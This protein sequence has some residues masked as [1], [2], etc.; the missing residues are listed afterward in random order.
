MC[1]I[2]RSNCRSAAT[3]GVDDPTQRRGGAHIPRNVGDSGQ[4]G[5][6]RVQRGE[7]RGQSRRKEAGERR[8]RSATA[9]GTAVALMVGIALVS[10]ATGAS[11]RGRYANSARTGARVTTTRPARGYT[12]S[13]EPGPCASDVPND[14]SV[15]CGVL[16][17]PENRDRPHRAEVQLPVA[18][19]RSQA[20]E[21]APDPIVYLTG[22]PG[23]AA[24]PII[25]FVLA[26]DLGGPRD[27]IVLSQRGAAASTPNLD[28][29][30]F[31]DGAWARFATADPD[32]VEQQ[33]FNQA[34]RAC[35]DRLEA[36]SVDL[37]AYNT[38]TNAADVADLR[39][40]LGILEWNIWSGS[41]GTVLAQEVMRHHSQGVRS[42]VLD[43]T[44]PLDKGFG[45]TGDVRRAMEA[46]EHLLAGCAAS[47]A[48]AAAHPTLASD[49]KEV[50]ARL[51]VQPYESVVA[52]DTGTQRAIAFTGRDLTYGLANLPRIRSLIPQF[53]QLV[54][55]LNAG[56]YGVI[57]ALAS[58]LIPLLYAQSDGMFLSVNC[59]DR[60]HID[61]RAGLR[62]LIAAHPEYE[63]ASTMG[64]QCPAWAVR[65]VPR[66]FNR[67]VTSMIPTLVLAGEW[68]HVTPPK[69]AREATE[70]LKRS[71]FVEFPGLTHVALRFESPCSQSIF[72]AFFDNPAQQPDTTCVQGMPEPLWQ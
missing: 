32:A 7:E 30:E 31:I 69:P 70:H 40:A 38:I 66:S 63:T 71:F 37:N 65:P 21:Q 14:P 39:V 42:V 25:N 22:G 35:R 59:A 3:S 72:R 60:A 55:Q 2:V 12:P 11:A 20:A 18:I 41:Y 68:D 52:D 67:P 28:C 56:Q 54:S 46:I 47:P 49:L 50:V 19:V 10:I 8:P 6:E 57:D 15:E 44:A 45:G 62:R 43:S 24:F 26:V 4:I 48:C 36:S 9:R 23:A 1:I 51:E 34:V 5:S 17:V 29:P 16:T 64:A 27:V 53:P 61:A 58:R 33:R 13:F